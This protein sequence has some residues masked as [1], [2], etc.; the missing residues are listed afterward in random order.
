[1]ALLTKKILKRLI[2]YTII[3]PGISG[4]IY[5]G[6]AEAAWLKAGVA[7]V[8][9]TNTDS[10]PAV[11]DS[12]YVKAL[13]LENDG[14]RAAII[15]VDAV[16]IGGIGSIDDGY[17]ERVRSEI[18]RDLNIISK[19]ILVNASHLHG[20][21]YNVC[22]DIAQRTVK[23]VKSAMQNM[24][25]VRTG[26]GKGY[27]D[28]ITENRRFKLKNGKEADIRH[29]YPMPPDEEVIDLGPQDYEIGILRLDKLNGETLAVVYNFAGHPY[30]GVPNKEATA[31]FPGFASKIIED[32]LSEGT[33][34]LF[35]QG[36]GGDIST[37]LYKDVN[38]PRDAEVLGTKL[39]IST[40]S[41]LKTIQTTNNGSLKVVN[42]IIK[43]PRRTDF[44]KRIESMEVEV[45]RL[46]KSLRNT[47]LNFKTFL[48]LYIKY[49][50]F[51]EYPS[52]YSHRY[53]HEKSIGRNDLKQLDK[54][55]RGHID[56]YLSNIYAMD[57]LAGLLANISLLQE[58]QKS[59]E[60]AGEPTI[61]I[62]IQGIR[63]GNFVMVTFPG[64]VSVEVG[65][66]IK[67]MSPHK[68]TFTAGFTNG[69]IYY[70]PTIEQYNGG[71]QEDCDCFIAPEWQEIYEEKVLDILNNI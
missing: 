45:D 4:I 37:I 51:E 19:N 57:R 56:K 39:G 66:N 25:P 65:L 30:Q 33:I 42:E 34:A 70:A 63:I 13:V 18:E 2:L 12:L 60:D 36:F 28:R 9:I 53:L 50:L 6:S 23:A 71:V 38:T 67:N 64:E 35:I 41:A 26:V 11:N 47:S 27:E 49:N 20:A 1:M 55:N 68:F 3:S 31:D 5:S 40:M 58:H 17:L 29:A 32:N 44:Q 24:V 61:D 62:E 7:K 52:Y 16:A 48:P 14:V 22:P 54:E 69:Y 59:N 15:T 10:Y 46:L 21:G 8:D 43:L